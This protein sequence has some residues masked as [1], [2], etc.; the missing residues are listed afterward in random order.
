MRKFLSVLVVTLLFATGALAETIRVKVDGLVCA[1]CVAG[2]EKSFKKTGMTDS[3]HV[4]LDSKLV[5]LKTK[6][7]ADLSD[8]KIRAIIS[9]AGYKVTDIRHDN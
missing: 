6:P 9:K 2:I 7:K 3:V 1:F 5:T 4:D 8:N